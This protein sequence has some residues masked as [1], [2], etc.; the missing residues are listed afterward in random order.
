M[1]Q[2]TTE[3]FWS[4]ILDNAYFVHLTKK[5]QKSFLE[6]QSMASEFWEV[7]AGVVMLDRKGI[8]NLG[9]MH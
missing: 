4:S 8:C 9:Q 1:C 5:W 6:W 3:K 7:F 2:F